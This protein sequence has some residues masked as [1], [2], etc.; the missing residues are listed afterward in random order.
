MLA[1]MKE[2]LAY[3]GQELVFLP[4]NFVRK[5]KEWIF[6]AFFYASMLWLTKVGRDFVRGF[7]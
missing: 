2:G 7:V 1:R 3:F 5:A 4:T 6:S